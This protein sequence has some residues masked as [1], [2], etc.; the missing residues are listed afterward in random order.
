MEIYAAQAK[1]F[2]TLMHPA[3]LAILNVLRDG[4]HCVCHIEATLGYRQSYISQQLTVLREAGI[5]KDRRDG[6]NI[7]YRVAMMDIFDVID[8]ASRL[9]GVEP[10][11]YPAVIQACPCPSCSPTTEKVAY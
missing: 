8:T 2:K 4:E 10:L 3:R 7:Y 6:W 11:I 5:I 1:L 9:I